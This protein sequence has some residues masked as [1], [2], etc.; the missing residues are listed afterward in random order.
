MPLTTLSNASIVVVATIDAHGV[1][2]PWSVC[3]FR[4]YNVIA[5]RELYEVCVT[6]AITSRPS[7][8]KVL[9]SGKHKP[10]QQQV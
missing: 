3:T 5:A 7:H 9:L 10:S 1:Q 6:A 8:L 4:P 2:N